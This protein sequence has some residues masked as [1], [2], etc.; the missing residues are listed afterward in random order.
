VT[1]HLSEGLVLREGDIHE[2][3]VRAQGSGSRNL[4]HKAT[5][6]ELR[7]DVAHADLPEDV[8]AR[9]L[10]FA[11]PHLTDGVLVITSR[12]SVSQHDNRTTARDRLLSLLL[13]AA[14]PPQPRKPT[15]PRRAVRARR[16]AS[17]RS[18]GETKRLRRGQ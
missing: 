8:K 11:G 4:H 2:R 18:R 5:A 7:Y 6:V 14:Q 1:L 9:L 16:L 3:F 10:A 13:R 17:K 15:R 12:A